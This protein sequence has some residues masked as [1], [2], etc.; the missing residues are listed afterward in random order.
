MHALTYLAV[1]HCLSVEQRDQFIGGEFGDS[2]RATTMT[3]W[4]LRI[5]DVWITFID[6]LAGGALIR[7]LLAIPR[8]RPTLRRHGAAFAPRRHRGH[9]GF[10]LVN[11]A[12]AFLRFRKPLVVDRQDG[13][14]DAGLLQP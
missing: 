1:A 6:P 8:P 14:V 3:R 11:V 9:Q 2:G 12:R 10:E 5:P 13:L 7:H 4:L